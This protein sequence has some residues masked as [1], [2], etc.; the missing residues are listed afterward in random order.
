MKPFQASG[1]LPR[2]RHTHVSMHTRSVPMHMSF[3]E[4]R[5]R[6]I[7]KRKVPFYIPHWRERIRPGT[8]RCQEAHAQWLPDACTHA[9]RESESARGAVRVC[10]VASPGLL[11]ALRPHTSPLW[12]QDLGKTL[13]EERETK[14]E[15]IRGTTT[16]QI[17]VSVRIKGQLSTPHKPTGGLNKQSW[18]IRS[19]AIRR[20]IIGRVPA[21]CVGTGSRMQVWVRGRVLSGEAA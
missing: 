18:F 11:R 1:S 9:C 8:R 6:R 21:P 2:P 17:N 4:R 15:P 14:R 3:W 19:P 5:F 13:V 16:T 10:A 20:T 12:S 7:E